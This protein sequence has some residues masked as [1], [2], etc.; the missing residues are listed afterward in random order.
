MGPGLWRRSPGGEPYELWLLEVATAAAYFDHWRINNPETLRD[1]ALVSHAQETQRG[2]VLDAAQ[3]ART[4][5][6]VE[7][8]PVK[9]TYV[10]SGDEFLDPPTLEFELDR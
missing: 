1:D 6:V 9:P 5:G 7:D 3:R 2:H 4:L 10:L 8:V